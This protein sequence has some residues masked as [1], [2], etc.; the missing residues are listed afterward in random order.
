MQKSNQNSTKPQAIGQK[1]GQRLGKQRLRRLQHLL[2]L[3]P[4]QE[5]YLILKE[6]NLKPFPKFKEITLKPLCAA[7]AHAVCQDKDDSNAST[8]LKK[9]WH[10][11]YWRAQFACVWSWPPGMQSGALHQSM[12]QSSTTWSA[13]N[14]I[15]LVIIVFVPNVSILASFNWQRQQW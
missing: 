4:D 5:S 15:F 6:R 1:R 13:L 10:K 2:A 12:K 8:V 3:Y 7:T 9:N 14:W 11:R